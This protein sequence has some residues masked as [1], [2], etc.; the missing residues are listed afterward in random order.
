MVE[1]PQNVLDISK[2][3][4]QIFLNKKNLKK[5]NILKMFEFVL[6]FKNFVCFQFAI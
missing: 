3:L 2:S 6:T 4:Y 5:K 1:V